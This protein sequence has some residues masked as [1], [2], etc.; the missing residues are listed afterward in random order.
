MNHRDEMD[1]TSNETI[2]DLLDVVRTS[3]NILDC[4]Y[5][6]VSIPSTMP[7]EQT[8]NLRRLN[9]Y[10]RTKFGEDITSFIEPLADAD[11]RVDRT[12]RWGIH[13]SSETVDRIMDH[14]IH[15]QG[16]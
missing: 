5:V 13:Y 11:V 16:F 15:C 3:D 8:T 1:A 7:P 10:M 2:E 4:A 12:D 6:G 9:D 14:V